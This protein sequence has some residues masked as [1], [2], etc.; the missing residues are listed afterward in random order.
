MAELTTEQRNDLSDSDFAI[1]QERK[2]PIHDISHA[3]NAL[4]RVSQHGT[5]AEQTAVR[6][7]VYAKYPEL[8]KKKAKLKEVLA[9]RA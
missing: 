3:R 2:Y 5:P 6:E 9:K 7:A 8:D 1:P 4:S